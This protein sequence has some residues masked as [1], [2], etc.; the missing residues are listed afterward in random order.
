MT[1]EP[2]T[3]N[4]P[5]C[6]CGR[7]HDAIGTITLSALEQL[8]ERAEQTGELYGPEDVAVLVTEAAEHVGWHRDPEKA[9]TTYNHA[10]CTCAVDHDGLLHIVTK[11]IRLALTV[12]TT[13]EQLAEFVNTAAARVGWV[14]A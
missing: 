9:V 5:D 13:T 11:L 2:N 14:K 4:I 12:P 8:E 7:D 6:T 1:T 10:E 3:F